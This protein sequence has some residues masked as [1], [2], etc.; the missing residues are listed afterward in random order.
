MTTISCLNIYQYRTVQYGTL[1]RVVCTNGKEI[2][3]KIYFERMGSTLLML[4]SFFSFP[5]RIPNIQPKFIP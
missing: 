2:W 4:Q 5:G 3:N 1:Q